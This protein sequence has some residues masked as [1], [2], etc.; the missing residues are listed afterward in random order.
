M[1]RSLNAPNAALHS[2]RR[3]ACAQGTRRQS[4]TKKKSEPNAGRPSF[5]RCEDCVRG[6]SHRSR[7]HACEFS[8]PYIFQLTSPAVCVWCPHGWSIAGGNRHRSASYRAIRPGV[9]QPSA[10]GDRHAAVEPRGKGS[11]QSRETVNNQQTRAGRTIRD[12]LLHTKLTTC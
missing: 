3:T 1:D 9:S 4:Y 2:A 11:T 8:F 12:G 6:R 5:C 10:A 7:R